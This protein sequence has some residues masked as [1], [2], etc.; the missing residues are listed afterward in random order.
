MKRITYFIILSVLL[1]LSGCGTWDK[2]ETKAKDLYV[3]AKEKY[4]EYHGEGEE[5]QPRPFTVIYQSDPSLKTSL[6][7]S[8]C[9]YNQGVSYV[10]SRNPAEAARNF[11]SKTNT[12]ISYPGK[13]LKP[14]WDIR[15]INPVNAYIQ[16]E[17]Y[18]GYP[19]HSIYTGLDVRSG[20]S[21]VGIGTDLSVTDAEG[22]IVQSKCISGQ[23]TGGASINLYDAPEQFISYG[24]PQSAFIYRFEPA[25]HIAPWKEDGT[26]NLMMQASFDEPLYI[27]YGNNSGGSIS[28]NLFLRNKRTG[29]L[30]NIV[31]GLYAAGEAWIEE[32]SG[33]Q[34]DT[35]NGIV[36]VGTVA[37]DE[38]WW[39]TISLQSLPIQEIIPS[40]NPSNKDDNSWPQFYRINVSYLNLMAILQKI[41][42]EPPAGAEG[43]NFGEYPPEWE[44][45]T[46]MIQYEL[47]E[48]DGKAQLSGSF[49]GFEA[50]LS[51][52]PL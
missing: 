10:Y 42:T 24:G 27:N 52:Y 49:T 31:I 8:Q 28:F 50:Y 41:A 21:N 43:K 45:T 35:A 33:I 39:S 6:F 20:N 18:P 7:S 11:I 48:E 36:H 32:N 47:E 44:V 19:D 40:S 37:S 9:A 30:L 3:D 14:F 46:V 4:A 22:S 12:L 34:Y 5:K 1:G 26:G 23:I 25:S 17:N 13:A 2:I 15:Y 38:S 16:G 29:T 51:Q